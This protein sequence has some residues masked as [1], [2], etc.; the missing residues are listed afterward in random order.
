MT[1][2]ASISSK[3]GSSAF[4]PLN[5]VLLPTATGTNNAAV[6]DVQVACFDVLSAVCF[7]LSPVC[8]MLHAACCLRALV[9]T[10][11]DVSVFLDLFTL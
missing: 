11:S 3:G 9:T 6:F 7:L 5:A 10:L 4:I 8:C 2:M 1:G